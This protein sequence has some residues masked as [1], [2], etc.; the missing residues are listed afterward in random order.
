MFGTQLT[1]SVQTHAGSQDVPL[2]P[3]L[4]GLEVLVHPFRLI[5]GLHEAL[6]SLCQRLREP[7]PPWSDSDMLD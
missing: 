1:F 3:G 2:G 7:G 6:P 5:L 4:G